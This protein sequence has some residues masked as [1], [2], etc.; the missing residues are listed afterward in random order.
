MSAEDEEVA[1]RRR[2]WH[3]VN[4][5]L[6]QELPFELVFEDLRPQVLQTCLDV[7]GRG[8]FVR[9]WPSGPQEME[10]ELRKGVEE[11]GAGPVARGL[12]GSQ[13]QELS[14]RLAPLV[15]TEVVVNREAAERAA[16]RAAE[17]PPTPV[18]GSGGR[19]G[20]PPASLLAAAPPLASVRIPDLPPE[21]VARLQEGYG[22]WD[23]EMLECLGEEGTVT[24]YTPGEAMGN[25]SVEVTC[26]VNSVQCQFEW[27]PATLRNLATGRP[28][29]LTAHAAEEILPAST[30]YAPDDR[31]AVDD[32]GSWFAAQI[33][34]ATSSGTYEVAGKDRREERVSRARIVKAGR[35]PQQQ[36]T[37]VE[38]SVVRIEEDLVRAKELQGSRWTEAST[39]AL[40]ELA[41]VVTL[42]GGEAEVVC[43]SVS[44]RPQAW[45]ALCLTPAPSEALHCLDLHESPLLWCT[46]FPN[47]HTCDAECDRR[48]ISEAYRCP[49]NDFDVCQECA[50]AYIPS[51]P[52]VIRSRL[53]SSPLVPVVLPRG[54]KS[55]RLTCAGEQLPGGC[56]STDGQ[57]PAKGAV[58]SLHRFFLC[59]D[60][61]CFSELGE[62]TAETR[63]RDLEDLLHST[64]RI[65]TCLRR[66]PSE[67]FAL[68]DGGL[69]TKLA[70]R[71]SLSPAV[72]AL[73]MDIGRWL[74]SEAPTEAVS[75]PILVELK[76]GVWAES[77][78]LARGDEAEP[79]QADCYVAALPEVGSEPYQ[80]WQKVPLSSVRP[81]FVTTSPELGGRPASASPSSAER[82]KL[83]EELLQELQ[84]E[85]SSDSTV[86]R[87]LEAGAAAIPTASAL[88]GEDTTQALDWK[89]LR[90]PV[91]EAVLQHGTPVLPNDLQALLSPTEEAAGGGAP[92]AGEPCLAMLLASRGGLWAE[93]VTSACN[94]MAAAAATQRQ[95]A[96]ARVVEAEAQVAR[97][98]Q[99]RKEEEA[100]REEAEI[101]H[102]KATPPK[103]E[104]VEVSSQGVVQPTEEATPAE[105]ECRRV[106]GEILSSV[107][108]A[109]EKRQEEK[110][111]KAEEEKKKAAEARKK[112][113]AKQERADARI[114]GLA[115]EAL[116]EATS[117]EAE[118]LAAGAACQRLSR[119]F[120]TGSWSSLLQSYEK[121]LLTP[122]LNAT[123]DPS[124]KSGLVLDGSFGAWLGGLLRVGCRLS[125]NQ[126]SS[127]ARRVSNVLAEASGSSMQAALAFVSKL[128]EALSAPSLA[129]VLGR[130][131]KELHR[132]GVG[133]RLD[134][135]SS[136]GGIVKTPSDTLSALRAA[137]ESAQKL[138]T[139]LRNC[140]G[141]NATLDNPT[142]AKL[143]EKLP[144][145]SV[146]D[147]IAELLRTQ[148]CTP[149]ELA[150]SG[151]PEKIVPL[152]NRGPSWPWPEKVSCGSPKALE[153]LVPAFQWLLGLSESLPV[154]AAEGQMSGIDCLVRPLELVL[155]REST[156]AATS[157]TLFVEPLLRLED[158][159]RFVLQ[160][161]APE[162]E[163]YLEWCRRI[164]SRRIAERPFSQAG[165]EVAHAE[166][167]RDAWK[168]ALVTS[169]DRIAKLPVH[170]L[171]Y[172]DGEEAKL[173]LHLRE[174]V[175]LPSS[176]EP[177]ETNQ[178]ENRPSEES[179]AQDDTSPPEA[180]GVP[181]EAKAD[182]GLQDTETNAARQA[183]PTEKV[184]KL[185]VT[186][187]M[188]Q[189][190]DIPFDMVWGDLL[191]SGEALLQASP[192]GT[193]TALGWKDRTEMKEAFSQGLEAT[194][195]GTLARGMTREEGVLLL[196]RMDE[197]ADAMVVVVD[198]NDVPTSRQKSSKPAPTAGPICRRVQLDLPCGSTVG[199]AV[200]EHAT[201][202]LDVVDQTGRFLPS[203]PSEKIASASRRARHA[204]GRSLPL[205]LSVLGLT[206]GVDTKAS[207][208][209]SGSFEWQFA[210][211][212]GWCNF[213]PAASRLLEAAQQRGE[214]N[215]TVRSG[216][217]RYLVDIRAGTQM[218]MTHPGRRVR[219]VRR[220]ATGGP[221]PAHTP[222]ASAPALERHF[223]AVDRGPVNDFQ[224]KVL[225][226][227]LGEEHFRPQA[228]AASPQHGG[229][230]LEQEIMRGEPAPRL[231][232]DFFRASGEGES[233]AESPAS[234]ESTV[235]QA[236][237]PE[238]A[239]AMKSVEQR[240]R[241]ALRCDRFVER[242]AASASRKDAPSVP[243]LRRD[244][245]GVRAA[246][247]CG[248]EGDAANLLA[249]LRRLRRS[250]SSDL[251][252]VNA[253]L[254][255]KL[256]HQLAHP[257]LTAG[258]VAPGWVE[259]M[260]LTYPFLFERKL[261]E[262]LLHCVAFGTSH[263]VLWLQRKFVEA[264]FGEQ[265]RLARERLARTGNDAELW[266]LHEQ[267]ASDETI[268]VGAG[269]AEMARLPGR[270][271][272]NFLEVA[273]RVLQLTY[274]SRAM[275]EVVFEDE[276]GFGD[277]VTQ[278]FYTDVAT[279]L[280]RVDDLGPGRLLW[281][282]HLP[283][284]RIEHQGKVFLHSRR[285]LFPQ[286]HVPGSPDSVEA[287]SRFRF[288]GRLAAKALRDGFIV[289]ISLCPY[290]FEAVLGADL[291]L[292]ALP[293]PGDGWSGEF[294]G[295]AAAFALAQRGRPQAERLKAAAESGWGAT[296]LQ[297]KG[298]AGEMSFN[299]YSQ[300][301]CFLETGTGGIELCEGGAERRLT[302]D[303]LEDFVESS[304]QWWLKDGIAQQ[305][306]AFR[307]GVEDVC[308]SPAIWAFEASELQELFC[309]AAAPRWTAQELKQHLKFRGGYNSGS[310]VVQLLIEEMVRMPPER[311]ARFLEFVTACPRL[312]HG[313]LAAAEIA[314]VQSKPKGA[315]PRAHTCTNEL[316]LP[317]YD[318]VE[319][320]SAKLREAMDCA[321][322]M[323]E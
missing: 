318:T 309:G 222:A 210:G 5:V 296:Y 242:P 94:A 276:T 189:A 298:A 38:G 186:M 230:D 252:W 150:L 278:S 63:C 110:R 295:A 249:L 49:K 224:H 71:L 321:Q 132:N 100:L 40:G 8:S 43:P 271:S 88:T 133:A 19:S 36:S 180:G 266:E 174:V 84:R 101:E 261:R 306:A 160:T 170:T 14:A 288:L 219:R 166:A 237:L 131:A 181:E 95:A 156:A 208:Q 191:E 105:E 59:E 23:E 197:L 302:I 31:V 255:R 291:P 260:P 152:L 207:G 286:P 81:T 10:E 90:A 218:N 139:Q 61:L 259:A 45:N 187:P 253:Q 205:E 238:R 200:W 1:L 277:G 123:E 250:T 272:S 316:Q 21:E 206:S 146:L 267:A 39:A 226:R 97:R 103:E 141:A 201:G 72:R 290:F 142:V 322:G 239:G 73:V 269:R 16:A 56:R 89:S 308:D 281:A 111:K 176:E 177:Q 145:L 135:L 114:I 134:R 62:V 76:E 53:H 202:C 182:E 154:A 52:P 262:Q 228:E 124:E 204:P 312:P 279:E 83:S 317:A 236:L 13:A 69:F 300:H 233:Q 229:A 85:A 297:A 140:E 98:V 167:G 66:R 185:I 310:P 162:D 125:D 138:S 99:T 195:E 304:A 82:R 320:L 220:R 199:V 196:E 128:L 305:V 274:S 284:S 51:G 65:A 289:P 273:E 148:A 301:C 159:E 285:G 48:R 12:R 37:F 118:A 3:S 178:C 232:V 165:R 221:G 319:E 163:G 149:Y 264:R 75:G 67:I 287:C 136:P 34:K 29:D 161:T 294:V 151:L 315:L 122:I 175:L 74:A 223:S 263:A 247:R 4:I 11:C 26:E 158:L 42:R 102:E 184:H 280:C 24:A 153:A 58:D 192:D 78:M 64:G 121:E 227:K 87:L 155:D 15:V 251:G 209:A 57:A 258:G 46:D 314:V 27:N 86:R 41:A 96:E 234:L 130:I 211:D 80:P 243:N 109:L 70:A 54:L 203:V 147:D 268:F 171:R 35:A 22:G 68:V 212:S 106:I 20:A 28:L 113:I 25:W 127:L 235:L 245:T 6:G 30:E 79:A 172:E 193:W 225:A 248:A 18:Q 32:G 143:L 254:N 126:V 108:G 190:G 2:P 60:C 194:G 257:L 241:F 215:V 7:L 214:E 137:R 129:P 213:E 116:A 9:C 164:V 246:G 216:S 256:A 120:P 173:L 293:S 270:A 47:C 240:L 313:G 144:D 179:A 104:Q 323:D 217:N 183:D 91:L 198:R 299:E 92:L 119:P 244:H 292:K 112:E 50:K 44:H 55:S 307:A 188:V 168:P 311:R 275:L 17:L 107:D 169:F 77:H 265:L 283:Q 231:R 93:R 157:K 282:E 117:R 303:N 33:V 115:K